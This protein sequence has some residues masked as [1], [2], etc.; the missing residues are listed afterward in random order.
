MATYRL[1]KKDYEAECER[2]GI[3]PYSQRKNLFF[4][5]ASIFGIN[6]PRGFA[7][8]NDI[9]INEDGF[10]INERDK[11]LLIQHELGHIEGKGHTFFGVMSPYGLIRYLTS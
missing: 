9:Y 6:Y 7:T 4:R 8:G 10:Y 5:I 11:E 1:N 2:R 3:V